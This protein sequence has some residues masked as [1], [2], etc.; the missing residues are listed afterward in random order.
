MKK[1][2]PKSVWIFFFRYLWL[3]IIIALFLIVWV[4]AFVGA[5]VGIVPAVVIGVILFVGV[6]ALDYL[7]AWL[8]YKCYSYELTEDAFKRESGV[9]IRRS[10]TIPYERIQNVDIIRGLLARIIGLSDIN[11]QTAGTS[12]YGG[13]SEGRLPGL[14]KEVAI[15]LQSEL[16]ARAKGKK[17]TS[18][19]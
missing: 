4:G 17:P 9:I 1:L 6:I 2:D 18:G 8:T 5:V 15:E 16:L 10:T 3:S 14:S 12:S 13:L 19:V 7:F 11:V